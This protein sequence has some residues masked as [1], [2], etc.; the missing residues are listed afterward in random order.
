MQL[1]HVE[2]T[3]A[4][5]INL[6]NNIQKIGNARTAVQSEMSKL[7]GQFDFYM[8]NAQTNLQNA[9]KIIASVNDMMMGI[10]RGI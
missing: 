1:S 8:G 9:N 2:G 6:S 3:N 5:N 4:H 7:S 10:A